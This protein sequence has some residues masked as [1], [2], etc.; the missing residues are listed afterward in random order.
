MRAAGEVDWK[1]GKR[2][3]QSMVRV[4]WTRARRKEGNLMGVH[5]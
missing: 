5:G 4:A 3:S 1:G 2:W